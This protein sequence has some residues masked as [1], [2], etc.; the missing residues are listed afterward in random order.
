MSNRPSQL[1]TQPPHPDEEGIR[2][3][4]AGPDSWLLEQV[5]RENERL[6]R[7]LGELN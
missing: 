7:L 5:K 6:K 1:P 2:R 4:H 3:L